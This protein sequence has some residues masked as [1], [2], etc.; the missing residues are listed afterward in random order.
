MAQAS[1]IMSITGAPDGAPSKV[2]SPL[3][4][5]VAGTFAA[6]SITAALRER[7]N[8][9]AGQ[10]VEVS[11]ADCL[12]SMLMDEPFDQYI[13]GLAARQGNRIA[14]FSPFNTYATVDGWVALGCTSN[15]KDC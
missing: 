7:C 14:R 3:S 4:D 13:L 10:R 11:L 15:R 6:L 12:F 5:M 8:S 2:G 9:G 1:G